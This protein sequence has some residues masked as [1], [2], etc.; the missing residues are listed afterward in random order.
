MDIETQKLFR[1]NTIYNSFRFKKKQYYWL[2]TV[3][4]FHSQ[5]TLRQRLSPV[6]ER[7]RGYSTTSLRFNRELK[8][9]LRGRQRE[10]Q[11]KQ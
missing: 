1:Q 10:R 6:K 9:R 2:E 8:Q 5:Q 11:K 4:T 7:L 3:A